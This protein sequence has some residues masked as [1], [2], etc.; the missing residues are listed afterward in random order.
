MTTFFLTSDYVRASIQLL[1]PYHVFFGTTFLVMKNSQA[2]IG[3]VARIALDAENH[4]HLQKYFRLDPRSGHFFSPFKKKANANR[5]RAPRYASTSLQA[6][7]TQALSGAL[8]HTDSRPE[9]G[10]SNNYLSF[11]QS[12][13]PQASPKIPLL[14]LA[15]WILR[16]EQWLDQTSDQIVDRFLTIFPISNAEL[17]ALFTQEALPGLQVPKFD[18]APAQ[19]RQIAA[20]YGVPSDVPIARGASL[21]YLSFHGIGPAN[22][23]VAPLAKRLNL[24]T[25]DNGLGKSFFLDVAWWALTREWV[26]QPIVPSDALSA[27][28]SIKFTVSGGDEDDPVEA[29]FD[30]TERV[31]RA[32]GARSMSGLVLYA[33]VDGSFAVWDPLV[34]HDASPADSNGRR[35]FV[36]G[37][38]QVWLGDS[39]RIEGLLR[40]WGNWQHKGT[41]G[42]P[43]ATFQRVVERTRPPDSGRFEIGH[44]IRLPGYSMDIPTLVHP[45]GTVPVIRESAGIKRVLSLAYLIVWAWEEHKF[46]AKILGRKQEQQLVILLDEAEAHLHPRW[47]RV[48]LPA[49]LGVAADLQDGL[50]I[51]YVIATHSPIVLAS[52]E[53]VWDSQIDSLF[54]LKMTSNGRVLFEEIQYSFKG[55]ADAW[56][57]SDS[58]GEVYPGSIASEE[59]ILKAKALMEAKSS[60]REL[61]IA[62]TEQLGNALVA[63]DAFWLRW[64]V[65]ASAHGVGI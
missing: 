32:K 41:N 56:L 49:L 19:W 54:N 62:A 55:T 59:A 57:K 42:G 34:I 15:A 20:G 53:Q 14:A 29:A 31:W 60:D 48:L 9:W 58:F 4:A 35:S 47:Q 3:A 61:I 6:I 46:R 22:S 26:D 50:D 16:E 12:K 52:T 51:Q 24:L 21:R 64:I 43:Y 23:V 5:W 13:L 25:G 1:A 33:R 44:P 2:P 11:L 7:N 40:D 37:R 28:P 30:P 63:T 10:W 65:Y 36:F 27:P 45:Y 17:D 8:L 18:T 38:E 39:P